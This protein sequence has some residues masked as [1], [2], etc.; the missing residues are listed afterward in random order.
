[1]LDIHHHWI[2]AEEYIQANDDRVKRVIDSW[3]GVRPTLHYSYS[4]DEHLAPAGLGDKMHSEMHD[5]K[6]LLEKDLQLNF[7]KLKKRVIHLNFPVNLP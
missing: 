3:R 6:M 2:R 7:V 5:I 4:R 1:M